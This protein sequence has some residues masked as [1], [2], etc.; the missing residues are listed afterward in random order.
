MF[1]RTNNF[2]QC[3]AI[4]IQIKGAKLLILE[5]LSPSY[6]TSEAYSEEDMW[7]KP[8]PPWTNDIYGFQG[9][10]GPIWCG[11]PLEKKYPLLGQIP[12]I[13][14]G[15][16]WRIYLNY[17]NLF[18]TVSVAECKGR[19]SWIRLFPLLTQLCQEPRQ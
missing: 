8:P 1:L 12:E 3:F 11:A 15:L 17:L 2:A 4:L 5:L 18:S 10:L 13:R 19:R 16:P 6:P 9:G 14:P 7:G